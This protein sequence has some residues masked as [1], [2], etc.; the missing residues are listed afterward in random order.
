[1]DFLHV[2]L[3]LVVE[4][5]SERYHTALLDRAHDAER[6]ARL[7]RGGFQVVEVWDAAIWHDRRAVVRSVGQVERR[8]RRRL[9]QV[10]ARQGTDPVQLRAG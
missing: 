5:Q 1:V 8:L 6:R 4:V 2:D 9:H 7:A 3:P 10:R